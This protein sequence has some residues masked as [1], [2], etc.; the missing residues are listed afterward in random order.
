MSFIIN[1]Y[2]NY[3]ICFPLPP[4]QCLL[5]CCLGLIDEPATNSHLRVFITPRVVALC[6]VTFGALAIYTAIYLIMALFGDL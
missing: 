5:I 4:S 6:Y 1:N 3:S 2:F